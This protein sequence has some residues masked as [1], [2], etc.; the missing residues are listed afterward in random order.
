M[1]TKCQ[2][3][4]MYICCEMYNY[5]YLHVCIHIRYSRFVCDSSKIYPSFPNSTRMLVA[6]SLREQVAHS[7]KTI[8]TTAVFSH[9]PPCQ[10]LQGLEIEG[11]KPFYQAIANILNTLTRVGVCSAKRFLAVTITIATRMCVPWAMNPL[12]YIQ[13]CGLLLHLRHHE[14]SWIRKF[15]INNQNLVRLFRACSRTR[16]RDRSTSENWSTQREHTSTSSRP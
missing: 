11:P 1:G 2:K 15:N 8:D 16:S 14:I 6:S 3:R 4:G 5:T 10:C 9:K 7:Y 13:K 12:P